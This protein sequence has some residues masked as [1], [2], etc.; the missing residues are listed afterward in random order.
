MTETNS[1]TTNQA[2]NAD[3]AEL[4]QFGGLA[5]RWWDAEGENQALHAINPLRLD[6]IEQR[7]GITG[8][9]CL[10]VGCGGG[11]LTEGLAQ[12]GANTVM[13]IDLT[14]PML[15]VARLHAAGSGLTQIEYEQIAAEELAAA[16]PGAWS[17]VTCL[18]MLEHV[19]DPKSVVQSL[20][21]LLA[22]G[23]DLVLSTLNR[24][25]KAFALGIVAGEYL[26]QL[27]PRGTHRY[28]R[29]IKPSELAD[30]ARPAGLELMD[31]TGMTYRPLGKQFELSQD[32]SVNYLAHFKKRGPA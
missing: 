22:P 25:P 20:A 23:G 27:L 3:P 16:R 30:W 15:S 10:D 19:P 4:A 32:V 13:G 24:T 11:L 2:V 17:L 29:F 18:E 26:L 1:R 28:E 12:R 5:S 9:T 7:A 14:E 31:L 8:Q 6:Y 21:H